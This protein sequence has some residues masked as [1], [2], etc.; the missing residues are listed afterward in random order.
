M[1]KI[2][3]LIAEDNREYAMNLKNELVVHDDIAVVGIAAD[4]AEAVE[5]INT[6]KPDVV[7][8]DLIMPKLDGIGVME[9]NY[10]KK[11]EF[12]MLSAA[13]E[14]K[15][16]LVRLMLGLLITCSNLWKVAL[17]SIESVKYPS[18]NC[19]FGK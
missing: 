7:I 3:V 11:P 1:E 14:D 19:Q 5:Y 17:S 15:L 4:G 13:G 18:G 2:K 8:L 9:K 12:I 16:F 6:T 10:M